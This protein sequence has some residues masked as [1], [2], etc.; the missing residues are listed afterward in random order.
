MPLILIEGTPGSGKTTTTVNLAEHLREKNRKVQE[1]R[2]FDVNHPI[3]PSYTIDTAL[4]VILAT[5][6]A[7]YPYH[8]WQNLQ[9]ESDQYLIMEAKFLQMTG[10]FCMLSGGDEEEI[11]SIPRTILKMIPANIPVKLIYLYQSEPRTHIS[12]IVEERKGRKPTWLPWIL[13]M[14]SQLPWVK[15]RGLVGENMYLDAVSEWSKLQ[16][17]VVGRLEVE[18]IKLKDPFLDWNQSLATIYQSIS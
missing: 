13:N 7:T 6:A 1:F 14:F 8:F 18:T 17:R 4:D 16:Q 15:Q 12:H 11:L 9:V 3:G 2:E 5:R 10:F